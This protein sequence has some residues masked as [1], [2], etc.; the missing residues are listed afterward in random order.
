MKRYAVYAE[1]GKEYEQYVY[2]D[3]ESARAKAD[4]LRNEHPSWDVYIVESDF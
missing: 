4:Q 2:T 3:M 1:Y